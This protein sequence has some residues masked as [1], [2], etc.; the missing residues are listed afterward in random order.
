M[1]P[2]KRREISADICYGEAYNDYNFTVEEAL[3]TQD[4]SHVNQ[5][6]NGCD[7]TTVLHL[8][9]HHPAITNIPVT[10][11]YEENYNN[12]GFS[13]TATESTTY[14]Q[15]LHTVFGCDSTVNLIVTVNPTHHV[16]LNGQ[17]CVNEPYT[18][19]GFD[20][21][22]AQAGTYTLFHYGENVFGCD[23]V[24]ELHLTVRPDYHQNISRMICENG[25]YVFNGQTLTEAGVYTA[26]LQSI[27]G[28]DSIVTLNLTVGAEYRDTLE[29]HVCYG[30]AYTQYGFN[31]ENAT[32]TGY[33]EQHTT[34]VN[35]CDSTSVLHLIVH[36]LNTT[37]L[38]TTLCKGETYRLNGFNVTA[39]KVGDTTYT[40]VIPTVYGCDSTI[41]LHVTVNP[42]ST[43]VLTDDVCAG[44]HFQTAG[45]DTLFTEAGVYTLVNHDLNVYGCDSTT[46]MTLTVWPNL[47]STID[48]TLCFG[49]SYNFNGTILSV[50]GTYT[51]TLKTVHNCDSLVTLHLS[52]RP[53][54]VFEFAETACVS[55]LWNETTYTESGDYI[56]H[57]TDVNACDST[58]TLHLTI[59]P[60]SVG[61]TTAFACDSFDWYEHT[62]ITESTETLTH[63]FTNVLG[64]DSV[65]T[66]HL[67]V[68]HSNTGDTTAFA[69]N[70]FDWYEH[71]GITE[72][73]ETLTHTFTNVSG[74]DSVV[75]LHLTVGH[76]NT[77]DTTA[78][79]CNTFDW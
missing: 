58:V 35:G 24:T 50:A 41:V 23:S 52:I 7:S 13:I 70:T 32:V 56:Q 27:Y 55:Y 77:G 20:T 25:S 69:C 6:V 28:C 36:E 65:V 12:Y 76:S 68:G 30:N 3:E 59:L 26:E 75:T 39:N 37:D 61:D 64:C 14:T 21:L 22:F 5:D 34:A 46:T 44:I 9:V 71:T 73:T 47:A 78:F 42:T 38:Y 49:E 62:N 18:E 66:L 43:V 60:A 33:Y 16:M 74:C 63:T 48:T 54:N 31:I 79:A 15:N 40:R 8:T 29:A 53:E 17:V 2:E 11:C 4:Y 51:D 45:F 67:T 1:R 57:F 72:S 19:H 10:L